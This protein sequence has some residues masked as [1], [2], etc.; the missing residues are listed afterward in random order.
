MI[1]KIKEFLDVETSLPETN[2][3]FIGSNGFSEQLFFN[4]YI[5]YHGIY[6]F[7]LVIVDK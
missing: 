7:G 4:V 1:L 2:P 6:N 5:T 3:F